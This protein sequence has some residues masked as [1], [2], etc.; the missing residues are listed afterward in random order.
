[1][2]ILSVRNSSL[3][4]A[5]PGVGITPII[6]YLEGAKRECTKVD[7]DTLVGR[8]GDEKP[9][10]FLFQKDGGLNR[11]VLQQA[12]KASTRTKF[13]MWY[14]DQRGCVPPLIKDR[15]GLID[16]MLMTNNDQAQFA[17][18]KQAGI[19]HV[20][21]F[22]HGVPM[23]EFQEFD[24]PVKHDVFFGGNNF[25]TSKF[26]LSEFRESFINRVRALFKLTVYGAGWGFKRNKAVQRNQYARVLRTAHVNLGI[27]HYNVI[28]YYNRRLFECMGSGK[29]H[30]TYYVPGMEKDFGENGKYLV[31]FQSM[32]DG[33]DKIQ[34][35]LK[36]P[37]AREQIARR[38]RQYII[39]NHTY[40]HR[41]A[42]L[43]KI[44][45]SI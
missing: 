22:Y 2:K 39:A 31:W 6:T 32:K 45:G 30:I 38:G 15:L 29:L 33:L 10:F 4:K 37:E 41:A 23:D 14:G 5:F 43:K 7:V 9:D 20:F 1:M 27:N 40:Q 17:M 28:R 11:A 36:Y 18:Y 35:Y 34:K 25:K 42:Q 19:N 21:T 44:L 12:K 16:V 3:E 26:P 13:V 8:L 24:L